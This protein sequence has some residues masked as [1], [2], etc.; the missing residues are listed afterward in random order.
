MCAEETDA[1]RRC[2]AAIAAH[3]LCAVSI[4]QLGMDHLRLTK[5]SRNRSIILISGT[6]QHAFDTTL[7]HFDMKKIKKPFGTACL[8]ILQNFADRHS[9]TYPYIS[10]IDTEKTITFLYIDMDFNVG[11][12]QITCMDLSFLLSL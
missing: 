9:F 8:L 11:A 3:A 4:F 7:L 1:L 5:R 2:R 6:N 12:L 10:S